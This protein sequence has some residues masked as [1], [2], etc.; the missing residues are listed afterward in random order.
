MLIALT[1]LL[2]TNVIKFRRQKSGILPMKNKR[3]NERIV[4]MNNL[5]SENKIPRLEK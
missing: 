5:S 1:M 3:T 2:I 4:Y